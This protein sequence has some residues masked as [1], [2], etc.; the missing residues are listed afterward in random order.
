M[1]KIYVAFSTVKSGLFHGL[2]T[3]PKSKTP[4]CWDSGSLGQ[5][6]AFMDGN[7]VQ[8]FW[9]S[10]KVLGLSWTFRTVPKTQSPT[11]LSFDFSSLSLSPG[12]VT[13]IL[14]LS[15]SPRTVSAKDPA[16]LGLSLA[17]GSLILRETNPKVSRN[18]CF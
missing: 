8:G 7:K 1:C 9:A 13:A 10:P 16:I 2:G 3:V 5:S 6:R 14:G 12:N 15:E 4:W 17:F 11:C 18:C